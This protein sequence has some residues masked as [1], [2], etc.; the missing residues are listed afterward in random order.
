[1]PTFALAIK[2]QAYGTLA[3]RLGNGLQNRVEQ[4][5]SARYLTRR[6]NFF[7]FCL[8]CFYTLKKECLHLLIDIWGLSGKILGSFFSFIVFCIFAL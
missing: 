3:D 6:Q 5:D 1:M 7:K 8:L 2:Q 4:F